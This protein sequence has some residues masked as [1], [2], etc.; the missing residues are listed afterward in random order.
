MHGSH[1]EMVVRRPP[2]SEVADPT[3]DVPRLSREALELILVS[4]HRDS[5][6]G[7]EVSDGV[8][9]SNPAFLWVFPRRWGDCILNTAPQFLLC[10]TH[11]ISVRS[12]FVYCS[13][14]SSE[15]RQMLVILRTMQDDD[16]VYTKVASSCRTSEAHLWCY[17]S[18]AFVFQDS[19]TVVQFE[20]PRQVNGAERTSAE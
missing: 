5:G 16:R 10:G 1:A 2:V 17:L 3:A 18:G 19:T 8:G 6:W 9:G 15:P 4:Q 14:K 12:V 13:G 11:M 20:L 7:V